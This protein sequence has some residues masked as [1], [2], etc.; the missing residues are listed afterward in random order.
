MLEKMKA[1]AEHILTM[2]TDLKQK[3]EQ[4]RAS[5]PVFLDALENNLV[6]PVSELPVEGLIAAVDGGL[7][8]Q[9][10][11]GIDIVI[12]RAVSAIFEYKDSKLI[13]YNYLPNAFPE[14]DYE[15]KIGLDER[16]IIAFRS[17]FRLKKEIECAIAVLERKTPNYLMLDG[18]LLPLTADKPPDDSEIADEYYDVV[19]LYKKL[20]ETAKEKNCILLGVI[21]DSRSKRFIDIIRAI[22]DVH[23]SDTV[24]LN[25]LLKEGERTFVFRYT[26]DAKKHPITRDFGTEAEQINVFYLKPVEGDRPL[27]VEFLS[28][29]FSEVA[30]LV[31]TL[32]KINR[33][34]AYPA[35]LIEADLRAAL[36]PIELERA[37]KSLIMQSGMNILPLR[38]NSRPFR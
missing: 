18:S 11:H 4:L 31:Y 33:T 2:Q 13:S 21:K 30:S 27:R 19:R 3:A 9:E 8:A 25:H 1:A 36:D 23:T 32:S 10:L 35:V 28:S 22:V 24:F 16:E 7:L 38:R 5:N 17:L 6:F 34:Y 14:S 26:A 29:N 20:Y 37:Q 15:I 12:V